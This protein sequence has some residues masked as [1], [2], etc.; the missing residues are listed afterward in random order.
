MK[1][2]QILIT[3][4]LRLA[5]EY[6]E[7]SAYP[8]HKRQQ[9]PELAKYRHA[10]ERD[11]FWT[12]YPLADVKPLRNLYDLEENRIS[13]QLMKNK[14]SGRLLYRRRHSAKALALLRKRTI[15][16]YRICA[17]AFLDEENTQANER[18]SPRFIED[19]LP[20]SFDNKLGYLT[21]TVRRM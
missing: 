7:I 13:V 12:F 2:D 14:R 15:C 9:R 1:N 5:R 4:K 8:I 20:V 10:H 11:D 19:E 18:K 3:S 17:R 21:A 16:A 6:K